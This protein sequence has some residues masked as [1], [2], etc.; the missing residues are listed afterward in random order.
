MRANVFYIIWLLNQ[1]VLGLHNTYRTFANIRRSTVVCNKKLILQTFSSIQIIYLFQ[2]T[3]HYIWY[4]VR[5]E[6]YVVLYVVYHLPI[7]H[8][9][10]Y[11]IDIKCFIDG[12]KHKDGY[13]WCIS[14]HQYVS[15]SMHCIK[16]QDYNYENNPM[17]IL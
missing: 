10:L 8:L 7:V 2:T 13:M 16:K 4:A 9:D 15:E 5:F 14:E 3:I 11:D 12:P 6:I 1:F 17:K